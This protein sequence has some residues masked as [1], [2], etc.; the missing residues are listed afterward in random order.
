MGSFDS[1]HE[2]R[3]ATA[4][5]ASWALSISR[6]RYFIEYDPAAALW[7]VTCA[8]LAINGEKDIQ[9]TENE[10][11]SLLLLEKLIDPIE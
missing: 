10:A 9:V 11:G 7:K 8:V 6:F 5:G 3:S 2:L 4:V 1:G